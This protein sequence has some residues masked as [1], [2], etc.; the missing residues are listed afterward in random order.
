L[1]TLTLPKD[2]GFE[3]ITTETIKRYVFW[4]ITT[5]RPS[6][7]NSLYGRT[8]YLLLQSLVSGTKYQC[9]KHTACFKVGFL[10]ASPL[11][12]GAKCS[13]EASVTFNGILDVI[14]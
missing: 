1:K 12:V 6:K 2:A 7:S 4:D 9:I 11:N 5:Y 13:S 8:F 3:V 10:L 14:F